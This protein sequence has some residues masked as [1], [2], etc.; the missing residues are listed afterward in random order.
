MGSQPL[1]GQKNLESVL[2]VLSAQ[3]Q[4]NAAKEKNDALI[5]D[6]TPMDTGTSDV[7]NT[8]YSAFCDL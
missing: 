4:Q 8:A 3:A 5:R 7:G 2:A 1:M 6:V